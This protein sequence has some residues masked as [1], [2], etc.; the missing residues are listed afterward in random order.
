MNELET[1]TEKEQSPKIAEEAQTARWL[2]LRRLP[3]FLDP[4]INKFDPSLKIVDPYLKKG[5][6]IADIGCGWGYFS[7][8]LA[9]R[10]GPEGKVYSVDLDKDCIRAIQKKARKRGY[11]NIEARAI[12]A[13]DLSFIPDRSVDLIFANGL[14]C[15]MA[16][17]RQLAVNEMKRILKQTGIAY[18]NIGSPT[19][20]LSY[21][22]QPEWERILAGFKVE[23][24]GGYKEWWAL[25]TLKPGDIT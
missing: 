21:I 13:A 3:A 8:A 25:V 23:Q 6:V 18:L 15:S 24:G 12:T 2:F 9:D 22:N 19:S 16:S 14:L 4:I 5:Q 7:L 20:S 11:R 17:D 10:V 1:K